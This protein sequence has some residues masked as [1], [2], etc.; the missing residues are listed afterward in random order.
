MHRLVVVVKELN[1]EAAVAVATAVVADAKAE[2]VN[3]EVA[4]V[5]ADVKV[6][7]AVVVSEISLVAV[8][9]TKL[10]AELVADVKAEAETEDADLNFQILYER[11]VKLTG[12]FL[13][14]YFLKP[15]QNITQQMLQFSGYYF[16][17]PYFTAR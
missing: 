10:E 1:A 7:T 14:P 17:L 4:A 13:C 16:K 3:A 9:M 2:A 15:K 5:A 6:V 11:P 12:L 8:V